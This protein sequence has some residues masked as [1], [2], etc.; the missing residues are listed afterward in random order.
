ML[1]LLLLAFNFSIAS[2]LQNEPQI[3]LIEW[4]VGD[5]HKLPSKFELFTDS[6]VIKFRDSYWVKVQFSVPREDEYVLRGGEY[7]MQNMVFFGDHLERLSSGNIHEMHLT[8][9]RYMLYIYY[10]FEDFQDKNGIS[11]SLSK[12]SAYF[13]Q[14][15]KNALYHEIFIAVLL[16]LALLS[17]GFFI[18]SKATD[19]LYFHY[20]WYLFSIIFFFSY[21]YG[22]L[23][24]WLPFIR[25]V[26][27]YIIWVLSASLSISY[28]FF[29]QAFLN[30]RK[31]DQELF[32]I[33]KFGKFFILTIVFVEMTGYFL[34]YDVQH[35]F[36]YKF[37]IVLVQV[38]LIPVIVYRVY[39]QKT[40]LSWILFFGA[41]VLG[42]TTVGGQVASVLKIT[43]QTNF[44]VQAALL[45][46][47]F[48][49][50][51]G[52]GIRMWII[53]GEKQNTQAS[54][55]KQM[56]RNV[57]I[58]QEYTFEL[59]N[60][61]RA[62]TADLHLK[63]EE[64]DLLLKEIHHRVKNNL[65]TIASLLSIQLRRLKSA[66]A[67]LAIED[68]M[69][70]VKVMGLI[71]KFLYQKDTYTSIDLNQFVHQLLD[72]LIDAS[73]PKKRISQK[74]E[75]D[76]VALDIDRAINI[77]LILNELVANSIKY[78]F[79]H[80]DNPI[81]TFKVKMVNKEVFM[82]FSDNGNASTVDVTSNPEGFGWKLINSLVNSLE[83]KIV[84]AINDGFEVK[85][86]FP[87]Y[88]PE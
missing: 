49:F 37:I 18:I 83:G 25:N 24:N 10:P 56:E 8:K 76:S 42:V 85:I 55:L 32:K 65:Q 41:I 66:P 74:V 61:V 9:G 50:S 2:T 12:S 80:L 71:H 60:K 86:N 68:S 29:A 4:S 62:R 64:K 31:T 21:Q 5:A 14:N 3:T 16:F 45:L 13:K 39:K 75:V 81:L 53:E 44:Y 88:A 77:G 17:L 52:I 73:N 19:T 20:S 78:A 57:Q 59:E 70:R 22:I 47:V 67:K 87:Y 40:T 35:N 1:L 84:Y 51:I 27:P 15:L 72:M 33:I 26:S 63:N 54:L 69:N 34:R 46:E 82:V 58:Q 28:L 79:M 30:I 23:G 48:I 6:T 36:V 38:Y 7:Y 11:L 43:D